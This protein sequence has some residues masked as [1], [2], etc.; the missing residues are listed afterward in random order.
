METVLINNSSMCICAEK[1]CVQ[2]KRGVREGEMAAA[3]N[4]VES[5][6]ISCN[7]T[8]FILGINV[9]VSY[10]LYKNCN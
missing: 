9:K 3:K 7:L 4:N 10:I 6:L 1:G 2:R 5:N 8:Y